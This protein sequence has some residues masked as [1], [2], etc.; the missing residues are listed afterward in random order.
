METKQSAAAPTKAPAPVGVVTVKRR[1]ANPNLVMLTPP[2]Q[3]DWSRSTVHTFTAP[4][5][6]RKSRWARILSW[7][8][9]GGK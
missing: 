9:L 3:I 2:E 8:G 6:V 5:P 7:L 4:A 1:E